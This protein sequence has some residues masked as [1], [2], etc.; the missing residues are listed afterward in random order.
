MHQKGVS[1]LMK[2]SQCGKEFTEEELAAQNGVC[3]ECGGKISDQKVEQTKEHHSIRRP[4]RQ[5]LKR[6][7]RKKERF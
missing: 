1:N 4:Q 2:C 7:K 5:N 3:P 6:R